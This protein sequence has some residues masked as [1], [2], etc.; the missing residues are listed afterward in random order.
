MRVF[1]F[2]SVLL[3][4]VSHGQWRVWGGV[5]HQ[6]MTTESVDNF[7]WNSAT[8]Q[9]LTFLDRDPVV[10]SNG[11]GVHIGAQKDKGRWWSFRPHMY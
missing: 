11:F 4:L 2:I 7:I 1:L 8:I 6:Y 5:S 3:P 9:N 10:K